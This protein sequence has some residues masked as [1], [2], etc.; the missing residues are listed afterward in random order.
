VLVGPLSFGLLPQIG[1][2]DGRRPFDRLS[3]RSL[4]PKWA[5]V[6]GASSDTFGRRAALPPSEWTERLMDYRGQAIGLALDLSP[7][8]ARNR[9]ADVLA[10][11]GVADRLRNQAHPGQRP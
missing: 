9:V 7:K 1:G 8:V 3:P 5:R 6:L 4:G 2:P 11:L 10:K